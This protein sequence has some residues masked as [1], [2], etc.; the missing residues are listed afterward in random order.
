MIRIRVIKS[1]ILEKITKASKK[2]K[3]F[4]TLVFIIFLMKKLINKVREKSIAAI[5]KS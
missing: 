3:L 4:V 5:S 2:L 1:K